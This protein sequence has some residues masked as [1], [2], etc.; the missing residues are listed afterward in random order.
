M[1]PE[2]QSNKEPVHVSKNQYVTFSHEDEFQGQAQG[3]KVALFSEEAALRS[4]G[5]SNHRQNQI[6]KKGQK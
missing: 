5:G 2:R 3:M 6:V 1:I 4:S